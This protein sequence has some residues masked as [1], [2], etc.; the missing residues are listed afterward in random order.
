M[1]VEEKTVSICGQKLLERLSKE[2]GKKVKGI[3]QGS[4]A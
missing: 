2:E 1:K 4:L 3:L